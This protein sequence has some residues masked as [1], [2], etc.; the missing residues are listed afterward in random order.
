ME[1]WSVCMKSIGFK[2][3]VTGSCL[4]FIAVNSAFA[5]T[6][7][8]VP[9]SKIHSESIANI[10]SVSPVAPLGSDHSDIAV[11]VEPSSQV[12]VSVSSIAGKSANVSDHVSVN[13]SDQTSSSVALEPYY[14]DSLLAGVPFGKDGSE[15]ARNNNE[16]LTNMPGID[17]LEK[18]PASTAAVAPASAPEPLRQNVII[19]QTATVDEI[20]Q[21]PVS[22]M[23]P[24]TNLL[25]VT[26][27][28]AVVLILS[29]ITFIALRLRANANKAQ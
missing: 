9:Q 26:L 20:A 2:M 19:R 25:L 3:L 16:Y 17:T 5:D 23:T 14:G 11:P 4:M 24:S 7:H 27:I 15:Y 18:M 13:D 21:Q 29:M 8:S 12:D 22:I 10:S 1:K 6:D 28:L